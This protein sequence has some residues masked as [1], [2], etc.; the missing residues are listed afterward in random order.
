[1][2]LGHADRVVPRQ[3]DDHRAE[4]DALGAAGEVGQELQHVG[5]I[6]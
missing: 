3:H 5:T 4:V 2:L 1:M 6:V